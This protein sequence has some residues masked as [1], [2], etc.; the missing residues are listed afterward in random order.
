[1]ECPSDW[2]IGGCPIGVSAMNTHFLDITVT[3]VLAI[4]PKKMGTKSAPIGMQSCTGFP[5]LNAF[6]TISPIIGGGYGGTDK[7]TTSF[8]RFSQNDEVIL[9]EPRFPRKNLI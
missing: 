5:A 4:I 6:A 9:T 8:Y 7:K 3:S 1:M 2:G